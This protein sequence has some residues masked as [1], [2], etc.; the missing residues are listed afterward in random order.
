MTRGKA[1][2]DNGKPTEI[3]EEGENN[4]RGK[5]NEDT[6]GEQMAM[7]SLLANIG[8]IHK[9]MQATRSDVKEQLSCLRDNLSADMKRDLAN[10]REDVNGKLNE[11]VADL[12]ETKDRAEE[13]LQRVSDMEEWTTTA[14]EVLCETLSNQ[15]QIQAKLTDLEARS[16]RNNIRVYGI[17]EDAEGSNLQEFIES[18]IKAELSLQDMDPGIQRCHRALGPKPPQ[19]ASPRSV[20]IYILE[21]RTKELVL[22]SAWKKGETHIDQR[23]VHFDQDYPA[24]TQKKRKAYAP[25][26]KLLKEKGLRFQT[27]PPAKLRVFFDSGPVTYNS[28]TEAMQD[29]RKRGL[30]PDDYSTEGHPAAAPIERMSKLSRE[31]VMAKRWNPD[32]HGERARKKN[33]ADFA[34]TL[35]TQIPR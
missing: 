19:N 20:V 2:K 11:I 17:P 7:D 3:R 6:H 25:I 28:A 1:R 35:G 26:R 30:A 27:P 18:F 10:F 15:V 23:R 32:P 4:I 13:A 33:S 16:Q 31:T 24:E 29:L 8:A 9:E 12:K 21:Y 5:V 14:K 22:R 34:V